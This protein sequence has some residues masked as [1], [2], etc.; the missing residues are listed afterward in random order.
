MMATMVTTPTGRLPN[1]RLTGDEAQYA[2]R[3]LRMLAGRREYWP[4]REMVGGVKRAE[5][6]EQFV[7]RL[8]EEIIEHDAEEGALAPGDEE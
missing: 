7:D 5:Q 4:P 3:Y 6:I 2:M 8:V 1:L